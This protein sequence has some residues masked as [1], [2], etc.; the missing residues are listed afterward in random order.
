MINFDSFGFGYPQVLSNS[1]D[2]KMTKF[3][4]E[5]AKEVKMPFAQ[6]SLAGVADADSSS[7]L[8]RQIPAITFHGLS[9]KW[10][11]YLHTSKDILDNVNYQSVLVGYNFAAL[12]LSRVEAK[13]CNAFR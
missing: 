10:P 5:L 7:F 9:S 4:V 11:E 6:A 1:S 12:F 3:A 13:P 8:A 2:P